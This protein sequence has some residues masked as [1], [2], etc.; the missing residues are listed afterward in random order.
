M[1]RIH[2]LPVRYGDSFVIE[3]DKGEHHGVVVV[4]GGPSGGGGKLS[5]K[6]EE[7]GT[8]DLLVLT[9]YDD[10]HING[11]FKYMESCWMRGTL[12]AREIWANCAGNVKKKDEEVVIKVPVEKPRPGF[13]TV[14][15]SL[16][17]A[18]KFSRLLD[19]ASRSDDVEWRED[20]V[21]GF[22]KKFP[23]ADIEV[24]SPT[25][26]VREKALNEMDVAAECRLGSSG[27]EKDG[28]NGGEDGDEFRFGHPFGNP[29]PQHTQSAGYPRGG[30]VGERIQHR[31]HPSL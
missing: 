26:E 24:V 20:I 31:L 15:R 14:E 7:V 21:E 25:D 19:A 18:V 11:L 27:A 5:A 28:R 17:Q 22:D 30:S 2:F 6:L 12:S 3:C 10:D 9:H 4:D 13:P 29:C 1:S 23:F 8:P 16:P